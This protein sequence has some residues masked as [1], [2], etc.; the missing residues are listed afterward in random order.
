MSH[1]SLLDVIRRLKLLSQVERF[2]LSP[3]IKKPQ[4]KRSKLVVPKLE[5]PKFPSKRKARLKDSRRSAVK[6][7][8]VRYGR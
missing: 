4:R 1:V 8:V 2:D 3:L 7:K 6:P 5:M